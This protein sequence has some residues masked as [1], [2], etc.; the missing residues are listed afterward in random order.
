[1]NI[2]AASARCF[3]RQSIA[4]LPAHSTFLAITVPPELD[5]APPDCGE[6]C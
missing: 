3:G 1:M 4:V 2:P 6:E 5:T